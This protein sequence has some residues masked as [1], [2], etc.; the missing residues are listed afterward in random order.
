[1]VKKSIMTTQRSSTLHYLDVDRAAKLAGVPDYEIERLISANRLPT[2]EGKVAYQ[3]L[4]L[5]FPEIDTSRS[6]M[7]EITGQIKDDAIAKATRERPGFKFRDLE[8]VLAQCRALQEDLAYHQ[9]LAR[10]Y[11]QILQELRP[12]LEQLKEKS[13]HKHRIQSI[14]N[15]FTH[16]TK[17]I[18]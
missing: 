17:G 3:D 15:W 8:S 9:E 1:M 11:K 6:K 13:E 10:N 4:I 12:K 7:V 16:K 5:V 2:C 18:W 14:I